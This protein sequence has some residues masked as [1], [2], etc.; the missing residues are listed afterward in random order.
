MVIALIPR[1][2]FKG[3][4]DKE[5]AYALNVL[6][7]SAL[8]L[9]LLWVYKLA[10]ATDVTFF[11]CIFFRLTGIPCIG[12]GVSRS[13]W[14]LYSFDIVESLRWNPGGMLFAAN[15]AMQFPLQAFV[16]CGQPGTR[17]KTVNKI[18]KVST[19]VILVVL[20]VVLI[21][22]LAVQGLFNDL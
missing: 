14:A 10:A 6:I 1:R 15:I 17:A 22:R 11:V 20:V 19:I 4:S 9:F 3:M 5:R 12:C 18:N 21:L 16:L 7:S 13:L 2:L 8:V